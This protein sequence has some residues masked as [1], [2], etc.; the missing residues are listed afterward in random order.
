MDAFKEKFRAKYSLT[1]ADVQTLLNS[2]EEVRFRKKEVIVHEGTRNT[3]LYLIRQGIWRAHYLKEGVD[4]T[5][6]FAAEG[7]AAFSIWGYVDNSCSQ[8]T[9]EAMCDSVTYCISNKA[10]NELYASSISLANLG[11]RLMEYQML[12]IEN[13]LISA[14]AP[15]AKERYLALIR[16]TPELLQHVPLKHI[17][18]YLW[19]TPQSLSRIRREI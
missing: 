1:E 18:S 11:R 12:S 6:W 17:A 3:H 2:M 15:R 16:E 8:I 9:I 4:T 13:W 14:G 7:E 10:L 19:V 5:L